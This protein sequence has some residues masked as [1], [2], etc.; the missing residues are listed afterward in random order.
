MATKPFY[1]NPATDAPVFGKFA[2]LLSGLTSTTPSGTPTGSTAA[3]MGFTLNTTSRTASVTTTNA[4]TSITSTDANF[5]SADVGE[6][7]TGT[8][9]PG[10]ATISAVSSTTAAT[11][12]AAA[13]ASGTVTA[14]IGTATSNQWDPVGALDD[15]SPMDD[16]EE[17]IEITNHSAAGLGLYAKTAKNQTEQ[18]TFTALE[19]T[20]RTLGVIYDGTGLT[21]TGTVISGKLKLRDPLKKYR[22][23]LVR[24]NDTTLERKVSE[25]YGQIDTISRSFGDGKALRTVTMTVYPDSASEVWDYYLGPKA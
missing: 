18:V 17:S 19:S 9:I 14:T 24:H 12:S 13:T 11:L 15:D 8:G 5:T 23:G 6:A 16:G 22:V 3:T 25:N 21:D 4:S 1:G 7:I 10:G 2:V 20:L